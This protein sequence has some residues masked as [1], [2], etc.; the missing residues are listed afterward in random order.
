M[1]TNTEKKKLAFKLPADFPERDYL[2]TQ[3]CRH[4]PF[5][6]VPVRNKWKMRHKI[7]Y[8]LH[9]RLSQ[10]DAERLGWGWQ[11]ER[12]YWRVCCC[13]AYRF[14]DSWQER[15]AESPEL[16][17]D[18]LYAWFEGNKRKLGYV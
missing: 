13:I 10:N 16:A 6:S 15:R 7:A 17:G 14:S 3:D 4:W 8:A 12:A 1:Q 2:R 5:Q 9:C 18:K 11:F